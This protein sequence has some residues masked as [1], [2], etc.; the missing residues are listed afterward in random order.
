MTDYNYND[1]ILD[2]VIIVDNNSEPM[3]FADYVPNTIDLN[4]ILNSRPEQNRFAAV[5]PTQNK[6]AAVPPTQNVNTPE[7]VSSPFT[8]P[9]SSHTTVHVTNEFFD[10]TEKMSQVTRPVR[11][12]RCKTLLCGRNQTET[13]FLVAREKV[14][15]FFVTNRFPR[16]NSSGKKVRKKF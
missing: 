9:E 16:S 14:R 1:V 12:V 6:F 5:S 13:W 3:L 8:T 7:N 15:N 11:H 4:L 10:S 2:D